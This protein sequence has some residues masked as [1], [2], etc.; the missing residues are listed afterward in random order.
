MFS[1]KTFNNLILVGFI[2][3]GNGK[4]VDT[5]LGIEQVL[6]DFGYILISGKDNARVLKEDIQR[7][8]NVEPVGE[9]HFPF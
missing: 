4:E 3:D 1:V 2:Y 7:Y 5:S 8:H 6:K 9:A